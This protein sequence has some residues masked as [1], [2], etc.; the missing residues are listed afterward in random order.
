MLLNKT[1]KSTL[2]KGNS[3]LANANAPSAETKGGKITAK[4]SKV[5]VF[6][7]PVIR[8]NSLKARV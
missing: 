2:L 6:L 8:S 1:N 3:S 5:N 7:M 4:T